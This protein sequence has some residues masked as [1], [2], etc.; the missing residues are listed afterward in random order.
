MIRLYCPNDTP[1]VKVLLRDAKFHDPFAFDGLDATNSFCFFQDES[2]VGCI[3]V[4]CDHYINYIVVKASHQHQTIGTQLLERVCQQRTNL[5][6]TCMPSLCKFY[7]RFG[8]TY[9]CLADDGKRVEMIR[10][11]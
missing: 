5:S 11:L 10:L 2:L 8:F 7:E 6:L 4:T 9:K 3:L 1:Y